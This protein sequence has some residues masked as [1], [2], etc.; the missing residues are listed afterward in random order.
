MRLRPRNSRTK[1]HM[2]GS[3]EC[4]GPGACCFRAV[5][6]SLSTTDASSI[7]DGTGRSNMISSN[8]LRSQQVP[9]WMRL[10]IATVAQQSGHQDP[11]LR[12]T[13]RRR[14]RTMPPRA[15]SAPSICWSSSPARPSPSPPPNGTLARRSGAAAEVHPWFGCCRWCCQTGRAASD[16]PSRSFMWRVMMD[17]KMA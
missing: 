5:V 8:R 1:R 2:D 12:G 17:P 14:H 4:F 13:D 10:V 16:R 9:M 3:A 6:R 15:I 7:P 11:E